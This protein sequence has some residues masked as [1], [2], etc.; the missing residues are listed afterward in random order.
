MSSQLNIIKD[1]RI[2]TYSY[3][4]A[5]GIEVGNAETAGIPNV[6]IRNNDIHNNTGWGTYTNTPISNI[7]GIK[8]YG[9]GFI[10]TA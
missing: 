5:S 2:D 6:A 7:S 9:N 4:Q 1:G 10:A 8:I 3:R